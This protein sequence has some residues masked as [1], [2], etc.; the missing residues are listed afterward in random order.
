MNLAPFGGVFRHLLTAAGGALVAGG[1]IEPDVGAGITTI[2]TNVVD[3]VSEPITRQ[4]VIGA[5][6]TII[7]FVWSWKEKQKRAV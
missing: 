3:G 2:A 7:G 6:V 5:V 1:I 4:E